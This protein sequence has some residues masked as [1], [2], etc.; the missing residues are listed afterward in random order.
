LEH[1][2]IKVDR[3]WLAF[4]LPVCIALWTSCSPGH[5]AGSGGGTTGGGGGAGTGAVTAQTPITLA[6]GQASTGIN[7]VVPAPASTSAENASFLGAS[8]TNTAF[9]TGDQVQQNSSATVLIFGQ[10]VSKTM[11]ISFSGPSD[12]T[13]V[14]G[15]AIDVTASNKTPGVQFTVNVAANAALGARTVILRATNDDITTFTGG[16]EVIP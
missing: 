12:I 10:G 6:S 2:E 13:V 14:P 8:T 4:L 9:V 7:I 11:Q 5:P 15:S 16:L 1:G 3:R